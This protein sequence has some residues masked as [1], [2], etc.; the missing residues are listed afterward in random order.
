MLKK[1]FCCVGVLVSIAGTASAQEAL[2][3]SSPDVPNFVGAAVGI[4]NEFPGSEDFQF[5]AGPALRLSWD[6]RY[7]FLQGNTLFANLLNHDYLRFGPQLTYRFGREDV[8]DEVVDRL[9]DVDDS[10]E[11]GAFVGFEFINEIN[12]RIRFLG[13]V[14]F[15]HD[16]S[17]GH[18]GYLVQASMRYWH[19][20]FE[21]FDIGLG[22]GTTYGGSDYMESFF[23]VSAAE[24]A[25]SGLASF[26]A[27]GG[28]KEVF[29]TPM[30]VMHFSRS[31]HAGVGVRYARLI[32][33]A[34]DSPIVEERG[35]ANQFITGLGVIY[36]W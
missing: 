6:K 33:D 20:I 19:P 10:V 27:D 7:L 24:S 1:Y 13:D 28:F 34:A 8:E 9:D 11:L 15:T 29:F 2:V 36:S 23:G 14:S 5:G 16:V 32:G 17:D 31:W 18:G 22:V 12:P 25:R 26:E 21:M 3:P 30:V 4:A 35:S